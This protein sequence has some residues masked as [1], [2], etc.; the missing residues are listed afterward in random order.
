MYLPRFK[1]ERPA[2]LQEAATLLNTNENSGLVAGGTDL[3]PRMKY[4]LSAPDVLVSLKGI[5]PSKPEKTKDDR[6]ILDTNMSLTAIAQSPEIQKKAPLL[7]LAARK[8]ATLEIRNMGTL[9]GNLCQETRCLYFNQTHNYQFKEPCF[10][11]RGT[12]CHFIPKG[13]KCWAV[14]MSD[15]APALFC[16][17]AKLT[18]LENSGEREV[19]IDG[20]Y[21]G[22]P[23]NPL[24]LSP[25][26]IITKVMISEKKGPNGCSFTKFAMR[27]SIEFAAVNVAVFLEGENDLSTCRQAKIT[28]GAVSEMPQRATEVEA[29]L[30]GKDLSETLI[31]EAS[32]KISHSLKIV[33]HHG[34]SKSFL[35]ECLR[36]QTRDA[37]TD[38]IKMIADAT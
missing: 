4:R 24:T 6:L 25:N 21:A 2:S 27:D 17:D 35:A 36:V 15:T 37:L 8:V 28:V 1:L 34:F 11:R 18:I 5:N 26:E 13:S 3:F 29:L 38:A 9:G 31:S 7:A 30:K 16:L 32:R 19:E 10:K 33:P 12:L 23:L 20:I 22:D 14:Y